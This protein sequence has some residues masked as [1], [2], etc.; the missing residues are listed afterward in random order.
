MKKPTVETRKAL[1]EK[2]GDRGLEV[3]SAAV[4][5]AASLGALEKNPEDAR[6][7]KQVVKNIAALEKALAS[8][9]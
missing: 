7:R 9:E 8:H 1:L 6:V 3:R 2:F 4:I 5:L